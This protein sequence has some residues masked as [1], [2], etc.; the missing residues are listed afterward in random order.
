MSP[1]LT[2]SCPCR[3]VDSRN[4]ILVDRRDPETVNARQSGTAPPLAGR[5]CGLGPGRSPEGPH[6]AVRQGRPQ[7]EVGL[8]LALYKLRMKR[9]EN[10]DRMYEWNAI[11]FRRVVPFWVVYLALGY[12][13]SLNSLRVKQLASVPSLYVHS[14]FICLLI[15]SILSGNQAMVFKKLE[16]SHETTDGMANNPSMVSVQ[17]NGCKPRS[18]KNGIWPP[19]RSARVDSVSTTTPGFLSSGFELCESSTLASL[20]ARRNHSLSNSLAYRAA[21]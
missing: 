2:V 15:H 6:L 4:A 1:F 19:L 10:Q 17:S 3:G 20:C 18:S 21:M 7:W 5:N 12:D 13:P 14:C 8:P 9:L 11:L 16:G